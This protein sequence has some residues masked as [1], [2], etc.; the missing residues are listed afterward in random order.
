VGVEQSGRVVC[1][2]D[3]DSMLQFRL[4]TG[5]DGTKRCQKMKRGQRARLGSMGRKHDMTQQH[6]NI[7]RRRGGTERKGK[8]GEDASWAD[9]NLTVPKMK[10]IHPVNSAGKMDGEDLKQ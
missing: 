8:G 5:D 3:A 6:D 1:G 2:G 9:V 7:G 10:K 4:E